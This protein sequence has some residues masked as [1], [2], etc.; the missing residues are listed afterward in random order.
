MLLVFDWL[1]DTTNLEA[2]QVTNFHNVC[3]MLNSKQHPT[4]VFFN[5]WLQLQFIFKAWL[6]L[7]NPIKMH[8]SWT[9]APVSWL[10]CQWHCGNKLCKVRQHS[11][12]LKV[13]AWHQ[14]LSCEKL[15]QWEQLC[16]TWSCCWFRHAWHNCKVFTHGNRNH[17]VNR[18]ESCRR[19]SRHTRWIGSINCSWRQHRMDCS[20][21]LWKHE[22]T[23]K[24]FASKMASFLWS[25]WKP[26]CKSAKSCHRWKLGRL[27]DQTISQTKV[28]RH[29]QDAHGLANMHSLLFWQ[30]HR[31]TRER[32]HPKL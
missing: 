10:F 28:W 1:S 3:C 4:T 24:T 32:E 6:E 15:F 7:I 19:L 25:S 26:P 13:N 29:P 12:Q 22:A 2:C 30:L 8:V 11:Q 14:A 21:K 23:N 27:S 16:C 5:S 17:W 20:G 18:A 9:S 31:S